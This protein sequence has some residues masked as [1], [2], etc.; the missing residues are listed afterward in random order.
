MK[1]I[2]YTQV[3]QYCVMIFAYTLPAIFITFQVTHM[4]IPQ[5]GFG[6]ELADGSGYLLTRLDEVVTELGFAAYTDG[7]K[8]MID[9]FFITLALMIGTAGVPHVIVRFFTVPRVR[10]ARMSAGYALLFIAIL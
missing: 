6:S 8:N 5:L 7:S 2:T 9:V 4:P 10:D 3:A 1:G